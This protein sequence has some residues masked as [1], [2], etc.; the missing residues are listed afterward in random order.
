MTQ[1]LLDHTARAEQDALSRLITRVSDPQDRESYA[2]LVSYLH[3]LP[4]GDEFA[5][6]AQLFGF[7]TLLG[8]ELP[9]HLEDQR[10]QLRKLLLDAHAEFKKQVQTNAR[11]HDQLAERL[12]RLPEEMAEGVKSADIAKTMAE[13]FRQQ[14]AATGIEETK[15]LLS[16]AT[17]DVKQTAQALDKAVQPLASRYGS[18]GNEIEK[19]AAHI[20]TEARKLLST[21]DMLQRKNAELVKENRSLEWYSLLA[22]A[23]VVFVGG[24]LAGMNLEQRSTGDLVQR[25]QR[26]IIQVQQSIRA[27]PDAIRTQIQPAKHQE[28]KRKAGGSIQR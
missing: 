22:I 9:E 20:D 21:A 14:I 27:L 10:Q 16:A 24:I 25:L 4:P 1:L 18:I 8:R 2:A 13:A 15:A 23:L 17:R 6:V 7:L 11:Y 28:R 26:Q 5:K 3:S 19:Q 12:G